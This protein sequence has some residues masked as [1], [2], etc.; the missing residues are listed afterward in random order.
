MN[1]DK[2]AVNLLRDTGIPPRFFCESQV[3]ICKPNRA[4]TVWHPN[5]SLE[6]SH[7]TLIKNDCSRAFSSYQ[8][9]ISLPPPTIHEHADF[10]LILRKL[11]DGVQLYL[12]LADLCFVL[13]FLPVFSI[14]S[15]VRSLCTAEKRRFCP[16]L[17]FG[18]GSQWLY[19]RVCPPWQC[20]PHDRNKSSIISFT[21]GGMGKVNTLPPI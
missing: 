9:L 20:N 18:Q 21:Y 16:R 6:L 13:A 8:H 10:G 7:G 5:V 4:N 15:H 11:G 19:F 2:H 1:K 14:V 12:L 3:G 17:P